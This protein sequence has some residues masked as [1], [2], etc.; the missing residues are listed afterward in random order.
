VLIAIGSARARAGQREALVSAAR[1]VTTATRGDQGCVGY[2]FYADLTDDET[3]VSVEIW[4]DQAALDAH[5]AHEH[6]R[7]F[8]DR[9][10]GLVAGTPTVEIHHVPGTH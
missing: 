9:V 3:I 4:R 1:E 7:Q 2:G 6:T 10:P 8:L 5:M